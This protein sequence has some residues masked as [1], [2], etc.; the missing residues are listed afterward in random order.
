MFRAVQTGKKVMPS[1]WENTLKISKQSLLFRIIY[2]RSRRYYY[3]V[4][5]SYPALLHL[6]KN[7]EHVTINKSTVWYLY[8]T[9]TN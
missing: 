2:I 8:C 7:A 1:L 4:K 6:S 5:C 9:D 3:D